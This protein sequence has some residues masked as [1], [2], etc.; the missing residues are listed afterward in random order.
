MVHDALGPFRFEAGQPLPSGAARVHRVGVPR[1]KVLSVS[2][3]FHTPESNPLPAPGASAAQ[4]VELGESRGGSFAP[5][6][7]F[8]RRRV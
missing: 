2:C 6:V 1:G 4:V 7:G 5:V 8:G 3:V